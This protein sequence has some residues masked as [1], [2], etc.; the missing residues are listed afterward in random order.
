MKLSRFMEKI[1]FDNMLIICNIKLERGQIRYENVLGCV[2]L[3]GASK[4]IEK[5]AHMM[6]SFP[7][8]SPPAPQ[9]L[10]LA[11]P[12]A[13][14]QFYC[15]FGVSLWSSYLSLGP[16]KLSLPLALI[17]CLI[18]Y[19]LLIFWIYLYTV[20]NSSCICFRSFNL[21]SH[22]LWSSSLHYGK[23]LQG[24]TLLSID[25]CPWRILLSKI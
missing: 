4:D 3:G 6:E 24:C 21:K 18:V 7:V 16:V 12:S 13:P 15:P 9:G 19:G 11:S 14:V 1:T 23:A 2:I 5:D 8:F 17:R 10:V 20:S 22:L 25:F